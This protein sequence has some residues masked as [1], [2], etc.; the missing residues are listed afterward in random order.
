LLTVDFSHLDLYAL[1]ERGGNVLAD[2]VGLDRKLTVT[3]ID[4]YRQLHCRRPAEIGKG[5]EGGSDRPPGVVDVV[6]QDYGPTARVDRKEGSSEAG[7]GTVTE[8]VAVKPNVQRP[9][10]HLLVLN[11]G[12]RLGQCLGERNPAGVDADQ[13]Q[14][15]GPVVS[16]ADLMG[17]PPKGSADVVIGQKL[18]GSQEDSPFQPL[19][20]GLK[21]GEATVAGC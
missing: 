16:L 4:E 3:T 1:L 18:G 5:I 8:I 2:V 12:D 15:F 14:T 7:S 10:R 6:D 17:Y 11:A 20:T 19:R 21:G 13:D 9:N